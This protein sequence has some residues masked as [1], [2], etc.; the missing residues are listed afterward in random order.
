MNPNWDHNGSSTQNINLSPCNTLLCEWYE[1][2]GSMLQV[3]ATCEF[4]SISLYRFWL[5]VSFIVF[6]AGSDSVHRVESK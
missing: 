2:I 1:N 4:Y 3:M 6:A 5:L